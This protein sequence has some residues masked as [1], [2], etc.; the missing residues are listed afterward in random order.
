[1]HGTYYAAAT[2]DYVFLYRSG[3]IRKAC[4][5]QDGSRLRLGLHGVI[6][7]V[8]LLIGV[9]ATVAGV[10][11][12]LPAAH[13]NRSVLPLLLECVNGSLM[14]VI[15]GVRRVRANERLWLQTEPL[16]DA[17]A[18]RIWRLAKLHAARTLACLLAVGAGFGAAALAGGVWSVTA[19][20]FAWLVCDLVCFV[21]FSETPMGILFGVRKP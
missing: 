9:A 16:T 15:L 2:S 4:N 20:V 13:I 12:W 5:P 7:T 11:G 14:G 6:V 19:D 17:E 8:V 18:V 21:A 1:M 10:A 3:R